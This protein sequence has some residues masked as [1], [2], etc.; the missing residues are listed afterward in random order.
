LKRPSKRLTQL[1]DLG[2]HPGQ[3]HLRQ[4]LR[5]L[6]EVFCR[7]PIDAVAY[8]TLQVPYR[9]EPAARADLIRVLIDDVAP[10]GATRL[11]LE[12]RAGRDEL[13]RRTI[14]DRL[15]AYAPSPLAYEHL[16]PT[17]DPLLWLAD[18]FAWV[19]GAGGDWVARCA[20]VLRVVDR[21]S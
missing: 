16:L 6:L 14:H 11:V 18:A 7:Q 15:L 2:P 8:R 20:G 17:E 10:A 21:R 13:D 5:Q 1:G 12:S 19:A 9:H 4:H 3:R